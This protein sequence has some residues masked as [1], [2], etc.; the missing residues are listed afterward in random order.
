MD[1]SKEQEKSKELEKNSPAKGAKAVMKNPAKGPKAVMKNPAKIKEELLLA[2]LQ[3]SPKFQELLEHIEKGRTPVLLQGLTD[4]QKAHM[5]FGIGRGNQAEQTM[6]I[7]YTEKEAV[8][9]YEDLRFY[10]GDSVA[11]F[12]N[13]EIMFYEMEASDKKRENRR[14]E[15]LEKLLRKEV[16][17]L[18]LSVESLLL[19]LPPKSRF[20][21]LKIP[22]E[23]GKTVDLEGV[24]ATFIEQG[25]ERAER[26]EYPGEFSLR[27]G[28]IDIFPLSE[29]DPYRIELFDEEVDSIR[30]FDRGTQKSIDKVEKITIYP[31][32][33]LLVERENLPHLAEKLKKDLQKMKK[34]LEAKAFQNLEEK[35]LYL[36]DRLENQQEISGLRE[37][38]PYIYDHPCCLLDYLDKDALI[39]L[40]EPNR[41]RDRSNGRTT[42]FGESFQN[43]LE[44]G[45]VLPKQ[46]ELLFHYPEILERL[47]NFALV[48]YSLLPKVH[49]DFNP[50]S[51]VNF[52]TRQAPSFAGQM[53]KLVKE[54]IRLRQR[55]YKTLLLPGSK[56]RALRLL[57]LLREREVFPEFVVEPRGDI[58]TGE[59]LILE[60]S[61]SRGFEYLDHKY[62]ILTDLEIYGVHKQKKKA[63]KRRDS[64]REALKSYVDLTVGDY[65]V[66][67]NHGVGKYLGIEELDA[68]GVRK[69]Y[70]KIKY[71]GTDH[72]YVP[73]DQMHLIQKFV[74]DDDKPP[75]LSKLGGGEWTKQKRKVQS[76][77]E[78]IAEDL[79]KLYAKREAAKG[80]GFS[81]DSEWQQQFEDLFPYEETPDQLTSIVEVKKDMEKQRPM[82]RL[83]CGDVGYGKT[84]VA[85][86]AAF[87]AVLDGK[88]V[89]FL[90]PTTILAQQHFNNFKERFDT[91]PVKVEMLSRFRSA[92]EQK[93]IL[94]DLRVGNVDVVVGTHR[95]LSKDLKFKDLGLLVVDEEQRFGVKHKEKLK[96]LK[97]NVDVLTLTATPIPRT[98]HMSMIGIRDISVIEEPP[99]ERSPVETYVTPDNESLIADAISRELEREGQVYVVYN[100]VD[101]IHSEARRVQE[102]I[103]EARVAVA[104]GQM[105]EGKLE[106][107]MMAYYHGEIDVLVCTT[108]IET[109]LDI[110]N[111]NTIIIKHAD[112]LGLSQLYQLRGRVG[113]SNR[114]GYA[115]LMYE[116]NKVLS[117]IADKRLKAVKEFTEFGS[118]FKI[119]MRDLEIR[120]AGNILGAQ[121]HGHIASV[122]YDLYVKM[123][124]EAL[125]TLKGEAPLMEKPETTIEIPVN[126]YIPKDYILNEGHKIEI[127]KKIVSIENLDHLYSIEEEVEDRFGDLPMVVRHLI[128]IA[129]LK[130]LGK[131]LNLENITGGETEIKLKFRRDTQL[132]PETI[133]ELLHRYKWTL[134]FHG[135]KDFYFLYKPKGKASYDLLKDLQE[136]METLK[137]RA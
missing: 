67:E 7:T 57:E 23:V 61:V 37:Y 109:G 120:G 28:I 102:L 36:V 134:S 81:E 112:K 11:L 106:K 105:A 10:Q 21:A 48:N 5:A 14:I 44:K 123:L 78:D 15:I 87:K 33:T 97:E 50:R 8:N 126:A 96:N 118:G 135:Q 45:E 1:K 70:L 117:E 114:Q 91:F 101:T 58:Q 4:G 84:E 115:Y 92:K 88:Q 107:L 41:L 90:V 42:E 20:E 16:T 100:R 69:D 54:I 77:V 19:K 71:I 18:V 131:E 110:Q 116:R 85:I 124:G 65:V 26:V 64:D 72:L 60:G 93:K 129:Y 76:A 6:I 29:E 79:I 113:R 130:A 136:I 89:A 94:E 34:P 128:L 47:Q 104:H 25:Y 133:A 119:A 137:S 9:I 38:L 12:E 43:L 63:R 66:H 122:G 99:E 95:I 82:D 59:V 121:Q 24:L 125:T 2:P 68:A 108:I 111:V 30:S 52:I 55:G 75:K 53:E 46:G 51:I 22:F 56:D 103:P 98:L 73:T 27:G 32:D 74:G 31:A 86:R 40:D 39:I 3:K 49:R 35:I 127:Y 132:N 17:T 62:I 13:R 83:L 80:H